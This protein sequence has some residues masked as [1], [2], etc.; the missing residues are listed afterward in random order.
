MVNGGVSFCS[1]CNDV[2]FCYGD[3]VIVSSYWINDSIDYVVV[4]CVDI[5]VNV[6]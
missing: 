1:I 5:K 4:Y 2:N 6:D 3:S